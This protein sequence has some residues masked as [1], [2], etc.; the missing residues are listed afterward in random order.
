M[1]PS[2]SVLHP[3]SITSAGEG[4]LKDAI[5]EVLVNNNTTVAEKQAELMYLHNL[6][7]A[8]GNNSDPREIIKYSN[9]FVKASQLIDDKAQII[10]P[11]LLSIPNTVIDSVKLDYSRV[12]VSLPGDIDWAKGGKLKGMFTSKPPV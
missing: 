4:M 3:I 12:K 7:M 2:A 8:P 10:N 9:M 6:T 5:K 11:S 1:T